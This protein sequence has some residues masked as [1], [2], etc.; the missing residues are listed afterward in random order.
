MRITRSCVI[1]TITTS[2]L[3]FL[4]G[5]RPNWRVRLTEGRRGLPNYP[6]TSRSARASTTKRPSGGAKGISW[7]NLPPLSL[8]SS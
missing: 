4:R 7:P 2:L 5:S 1:G 6:M 3:Y 8:P